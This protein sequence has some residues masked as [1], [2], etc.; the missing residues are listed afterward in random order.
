MTDILEIKGI[1]NALASSKDFFEEYQEIE[2]PLLYSFIDS[3]GETRYGNVIRGK[4]TDLQVEIN[5][6]TRSYF[7]LKFYLDSH[8][9]DIPCTY[10][11]INSL[12]AFYDI[13]I[14]C[15]FIEKVERDVFVSNIVLKKED[16]FFCQNIIYS[17]L[18][19]IN[20]ESKFPIYMN[21]KIFVQKGNRKNN[22][23]KFNG[24]KNDS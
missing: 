3:M 17:D 23:I 16:R 22:K 20:R 6:G 12:C 21:N 7:N 18:V 4:D 14:V 24:D 11:F 13:E 15:G 19:G 9:E 1:L 10:G 8:T 5:I 2:P